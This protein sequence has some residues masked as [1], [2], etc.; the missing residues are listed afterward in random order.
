MTFSEQS[1]P[2]SALSTRFQHFKDACA[3]QSKLEAQIVELMKKMETA[4]VN[5]VRYAESELE[6]VRNRA[7]AVRAEMEQTRLA[8][9]ISTTKSS[10]K[11]CLDRSSTSHPLDHPIAQ[12]LLP[13]GELATSC[14]AG[15]VPESMIPSSSRRITPLSPSEYDDCFLPESP[16]YPPSGLKTH[17][18]VSDAIT[19]AHGEDGGC[20]DETIRMMAQRY[21]KV[22]QER[23]SLEVEIEKEL[24]AEESMAT[25]R[26]TDAEQSL[27]DMRER[28]AAMVRMLNQAGGG[29]SFKLPSLENIAVEGEEMP[30]EMVAA[31]SLPVPIVV[32][33]P[34]SADNPA[35]KGDK[36]TDPPSFLDAHKPVESL[37]DAFS[38]SFTKYFDDSLDE[39]FSN[40]SIL[41]PSLLI[42]IGLHRGV[43][44]TPA[45]DSQFYSPKLV[46]AVAENYWK[47]DA[48]DPVYGAMKF[49]MR[50]LILPR[51]W[52]SVI[53]VQ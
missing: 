23:R 30:S 46:E 37:W 18:D 48:V 14:P 2:E 38:E 19:H 51:K 16:H 41:V 31:T 25:E 52:D 43:D 50:S 53:R 24:E 47:L 49:L 9:G 35:E 15:E 12:P 44:S 1:L 26:I 45:D 20:H 4:A 3:E 17:S 5:T 10:E 39:F 11:S 7:A 29:N 36:S 21:I 32:A 34:A 42:E 13:E 6:K 27:K 28:A 33:E 8:Y 40:P 22:S